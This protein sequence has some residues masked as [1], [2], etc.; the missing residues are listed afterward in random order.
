VKGYRRLD[1]GRR[2]DQNVLHR[3]PTPDPSTARALANAVSRALFR[4]AAEAVQAQIAV[5][6]AKPVK[7]RKRPARRKRAEA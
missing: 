6:P 1:V 4:E 2:A 3:D 7:E 5:A